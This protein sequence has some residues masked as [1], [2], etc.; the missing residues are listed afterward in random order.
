MDISISCTGI[1]KIMY[2]LPQPLKVWATVVFFAI[3]VCVGRARAEDSTT[4]ATVPAES[5]VRKEAGSVKK[6]TQL[7]LEE[8]SSIQVDTVVGAS[9]HE[10]K[11]T[12]APSSVSIITQD[13]I[14]KYGHRTLSDILNSV[15]GFYVNYDRG[16]SYIGVRGF[17]RPGDYGGRMLLIV[18]GH[19]LND[20]VYDTAASGTDFPLD[21]D[22]ID[23]VEIIR[24][25]GSSLYGNNAFFGVINVIT[26]RGRDF[27]GAELS[28][29]YGSFDTWTG[30][31]SYGRRFTNGLEFLVSGTL[32]DSAG[33]DRLSY[34]EFVAEN[35]DGGWARNAFASLSYKD[36][37]LQG[38]FTRRRKDWPTAAYDTVPNSQDPRF[39]STDERAWTDLTFK[40]E[41]GDEWLVMARS[42]FDRYQY[43][44]D[45]PYD[46]DADP[47]TRPDLNRDLA[48]ATSGGLDL[49]VNKNLWES[50]QLTVGG[51]WRHDF[52]LLQQNWDVDPYYEYTDSNPTSAILLRKW[53]FSGD[54]VS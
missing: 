29:S 38:G 23:R 32:L 7:S 51:E 10:Q 33:Q 17:N 11:T 25:P 43:H 12:E 30:R 53:R 3:C 15:R 40:R 18:D 46:Y 2:G 4:P 49:S 41:F 39:F 31:A 52:E 13:D 26:R 34:P 24:G 20:G 37:S 14:K 6:L 16:Y 5:I 19:R 50:H 9:R 8:L 44:A 22:L 45:Y 21:V 1:K 54:F 27:D 48:I 42:Y 28:G 47:L 35:L 36:F